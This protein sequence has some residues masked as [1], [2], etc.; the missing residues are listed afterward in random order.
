MFQKFVANLQ[1]IEIEGFLIWKVFRTAGL[2]S[3]SH[4]TDLNF[5]KTCS[6][7]SQHHLHH[8]QHHHHH[9]LHPNIVRYF[10]IESNFAERKQI[11]YSHL[12]H[13]HNNFKNSILDLQNRSFWLL[14]WPVMHF[15]VVGWSSTFWHT[16]IHG[17]P[18]KQFHKKTWTKTLL[19]VEKCLKSTMSSEA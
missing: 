15:K 18:I 10:P 1:K 13:F 19:L 8:L 14:V 17:W 12:L 16:A 9:H 6:F 7:S 5:H 4:Q 3:S 11:F 2:C